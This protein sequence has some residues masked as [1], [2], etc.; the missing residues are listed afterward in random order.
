MKLNRNEPCSCGSGL[1]YKKCCLNNAVKS[2][3]LS[4]A[5]QK[6]RSTDAELVEPLMKHAMTL[7]GKQGLEAA[8]EE[9]HVFSKD[10]LEMGRGDMVFEQAF[11]PW[12]LY[13]WL[14]S[15][16][17]LIEK[18]PPVIVA[19][20]YL[21]RYPR[22][23]NSYQKSFILANVQS[24]YSIY[25]V[26]HVV[27]QQSITLRD[28][29][30]GHQVTIHE[31][32]GS[33]SLEKGYVLMARVLTLNEESIACGMY[34]QPL[35]SQYLL[36]FVDLKQ[37]FSHNLPFTDDMLFEV[38]LEI[39]EHFINEVN[40]LLENPYPQVQNTDGD[41]LS[42][43]KI[44]YALACTPQK[45]FDA[46]ADLAMGVD[47][48]ELSQEGIYD[49][50]QHLIKIEFPWLARGNSAHKDW[51]NTVHGHMIIK[52]NSLTIEVNSEARAKAVLLEINSR[53]TTK[54]AT[55]LH[56]EQKSIKEL[57]EEPHE[58][59]PKP[60]MDSPELQ[61]MVKELSARHWKSWLDTKIPALNHITPREAAKTAPGRERLEALFVDFHQKNQAGFSQQPVDLYF[62]RKELG[63]T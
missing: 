47:K 32:R 46:L 56:T 40:N 35:P 28:V 18:I 4:F 1:K 36:S 13:N 31:K 16:D 44:H 11:M 9:F 58:K 10:T 60:S 49:A 24:Q 45:A 30:R 62:L 48:S 14:P 25:E 29:L 39:R 2:T 53:L 33:E 12:F 5:W 38:D 27:R 34:P 61:A 7:F 43:N 55:Y 21:T 50:H 20:D 15:S 41:E 37:H 51:E 17:E 26:V 57:M 42:I 6:M 8:W 54:E 23:L 19:E 22:R 52:E 59:K 63:M 3:T